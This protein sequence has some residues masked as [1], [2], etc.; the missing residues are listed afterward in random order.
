MRIA[1]QR[2]HFKKIVTIYAEGLREIQAYINS[3]KFQGFDNNYVNPD[4]IRMRINEVFNE[5]SRNAEV[6]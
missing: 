5:V 1:E 4:D 6:I 2:D 3:D